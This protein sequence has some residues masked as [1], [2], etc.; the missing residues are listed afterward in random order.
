M[1]TCILVGEGDLAVAVHPVVVGICNLISALQR[2]GFG[3]STCI[4]LPN[5]VRLTYTSVCTCC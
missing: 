5:V 1:L 4:L 2:W 3:V